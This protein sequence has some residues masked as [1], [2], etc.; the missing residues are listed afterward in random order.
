MNKLLIAVFGS[1]LLLATASA[2]HH[3]GGKHKNKLISKLE[4][5]EEQKQPVA[6]ILKEQ[7]KKKRAIKRSAMEQIKPQMAAL[8]EETRQRLDGIL[9]EE[10]LRKYDALSSKRHKRMHKRHSHR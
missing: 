6:E 3:T 7:W 2:D 1:M 9:S 10:Q 4:L 5:T 8:D